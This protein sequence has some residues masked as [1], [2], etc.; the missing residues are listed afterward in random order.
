MFFR[1]SVRRNSIFEAL[2]KS[3]SIPHFQR[4]VRRNS[5]FRSFFITRFFL[6]ELFW[7]FVCKV[8]LGFFEYSPQPT[9]TRLAWAKACWSPKGLLNEIRQGSFIIVGLRGKLPKASDYF[10]FSREKIKE[11]ILLSY[12]VF[13]KCQ[14]R[15]LW[16]SFLTMSFFSKRGK[17]TC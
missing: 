6:N 10:L 4:F 1:N 13:F 17:K 16:S 14:T 7:D 8:E 11:L 5:L 2:L 15:L 12:P 9:T 3:I